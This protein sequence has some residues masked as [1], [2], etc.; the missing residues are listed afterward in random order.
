MNTRFGRATTQDVTTRF[1][2]GQATRC[3]LLLPDPGEV[4]NCSLPY[5]GEA[6]HSRWNFSLPE[7][8]ELK[9]PQHSR[10]NCSLS[11]LRKL[12]H[13]TQS[14]EIQYWCRNTTPQ[15]TGATERPSTVSFVLRFSITD[16]RGMNSNAA[17]SY[18]GWQGY[19]SQDYSG[20][21]A[22]Q[23]QRGAG[24]YVPYFQKQ[25]SDDSNQNQG[26]Q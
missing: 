25:R 20:R 26:T 12:K 2:R 4:S 15:C 16:W 23:S 11:N 10:R 14:W 1:G 9:H 17:Q 22:D 18:T 8:E 5:T 19:P 13:S 7:P 24:R 3:N 21:T 6:K